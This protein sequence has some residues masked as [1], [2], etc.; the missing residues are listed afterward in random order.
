M[1][2]A[3]DCSAIELAAMEITPATFA[4]VSDETVLTLLRS[5]QQLLLRWTVEERWKIYGIYT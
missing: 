5:T 4:E 3:N 1:V 2:F